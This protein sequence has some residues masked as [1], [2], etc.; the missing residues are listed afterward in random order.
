MRFALVDCRLVV[1]GD[2]ISGANEIITGLLDDP[3][4]ADQN[5]R[6]LL[7]QRWTE[8]GGAGTIQIK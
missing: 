4:S 1:W 8:L 2:A 3:L 7:H 6:A 5:Q